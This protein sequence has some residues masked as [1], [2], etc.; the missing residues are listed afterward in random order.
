MKQVFLSASIAA[1]TTVDVTPSI[2]RQA[3]FNRLINGMCISGATI[4]T[5]K[6]HVLR[7]NLEVAGIANGVTRAAG[8]PIDFVSDLVPIGEVVEGNDQLT[9][10]VDNTTGGALT[11]Y[12][13]Y[14][15]DEEQ[16]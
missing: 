1:N 6:L 5:G 12:I 14:D 15:I 10:N 8:Q 13:A 4:N 9:F 11:Y 7:N 3:P 16:G 2:V